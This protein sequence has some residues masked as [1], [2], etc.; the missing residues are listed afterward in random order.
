MVLTGHFCFI[1]CD[2]KAYAPLWWW[3][4]LD[5]EKAAVTHCDFAKFVAKVISLST[6]YPLRLRNTTEETLNDWR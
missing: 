2:S 4:V 1:G 6:W 5:T 3:I